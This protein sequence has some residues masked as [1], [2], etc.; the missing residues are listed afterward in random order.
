MT[1]TQKRNG[2]GSYAYDQ[3]WRHER[4]RL[5]GMDELW[6]PGTKALLEDLGLAAG[7]R[8]L[9]VGAG[10]GSIAAWLA[11][12]VGGSGEVLATDVDTSHLDGLSRP[13]LEVR[14]H[15]VLADPLPGDHFDLAHARLVVEHLGDLALE[16]M[17]T[18]LKPGGWLMVESLDWTTPTIH[19]G[20]EVAERVIAG[21]LRLMSGSGFD[22][23]YGRKLVHTLESRGLE[24]V[25]AEGRVRVY[26]GGSLGAS[27]LRLS[28]ASLGPTLEQNGVRGEDLEATIATLDDPRVVLVTPPMIAAWGLKPGPD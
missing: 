25:H 27:F 8:C 16:R 7:W 1:S 24:R 9:E 23:Q 13:G 28:L 5:A 6:D 15:D 2:S 18:P 26:R 14:R 11:D 22:P 3:G 12:Q 4:S 17:I 10:S 20:H 19:P 21:L